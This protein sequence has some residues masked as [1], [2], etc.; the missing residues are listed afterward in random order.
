MERH[1]LATGMELAPVQFEDYD[2]WVLG[3]ARW[4]DEVLIVR[5]GNDSQSGNQIAR[6]DMTDGSLLGVI[7]MAGISGFGQI[8]GLAC[9]PADLLA[10]EG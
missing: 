5:S 2:G 8:T 9:G 7:D 3:L 10:P 1:D 4:D 6:Y